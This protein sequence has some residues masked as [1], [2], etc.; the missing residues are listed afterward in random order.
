MGQTWS[1][2]EDAKL[3]KSIHQKI[4]MKEIA[5]EHQRTEGGIKSRLR[6]LATEY[7]FNDGLPVE[8][9]MKY[10]GLNR[11]Q[12]EDAIKKRESLE[13]AKKA[14]TVS[15]KHKDDEL[16][17]LLREINDKLNILIEHKKNKLKSE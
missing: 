8:T 12:V 7:H 11:I 15:K 17:E 1:E 14:T 10:T 16:I 9:I 5:N 3:L 13:G 2:E 4:P 6:F